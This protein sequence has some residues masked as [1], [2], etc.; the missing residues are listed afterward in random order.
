M[1]PASPQVL[2][3]LGKLYSALEKYS[4]AIHV[5]EKMVTV[6]PNS[7]LGATL[8]AEAYRHMG[9]LE[10]AKELD[11]TR[12]DV[13]VSGTSV[14]AFLSVAREQVSQKNFDLA[15]N[16]FREA[17]KKDNSSVTV[18]AEFGTF[19]AQRNKCSEAV[20]YLSSALEMLESGRTMNKKE[21][22]FRES[23]VVELQN[24][25]QRVHPEQEREGGE[26]NGKMKNYSSTKYLRRSP[27]SSEGNNSTHYI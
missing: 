20:L 16:Y 3:S 13:S 15:E 19:L 11:G 6:M 5:L 26:K 21:R 9:S 24:C 23:I 22:E 10:K 4:N 12:E 8:L 7:K 25:A 27:I 2:Y 18:L 17:L 14:K 1:S